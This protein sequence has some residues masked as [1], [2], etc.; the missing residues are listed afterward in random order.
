MGSKNKIGD[1]Q[2]SEIGSVLSPVEGRKSYRLATS[3]HLASI[4]KLLSA[5]TEILKEEP[6]IDKSVIE[7]LRQLRVKIRQAL[8][9]STN[10]HPTSPPGSAPALW[11]ER[12]DKNE[13]PISF[14]KRVYSKWIGKEFTRADIKRLDKHLYDAIY[15]LDNPGEKLTQ[16]GLLTTR[17]IND[18]K[19]SKAGQLKRPPK[20]KKMSELP[21]SE[22][23]N[24]RL[25]YISNRRKRSKKQ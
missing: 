8:S 3:K 1:A 25:Y 17:Q 9:V 14:V 13:D 12:P 21:A 10:E 16:I 11:R 19:L 18:L 24:A 23:E 20:S 6:S 5:A 4:E 22:K 7:Q 2:V 15:N